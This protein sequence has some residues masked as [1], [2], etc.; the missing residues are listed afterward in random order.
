MPPDLGHDVAPI[1][2]MC[3]MGVAVV[4]AAIVAGCGTSTSA[5]PAIAPATSLAP[6]GSPSPTAPAAPVTSPSPTPDISSAALRTLSRMPVTGMEG[7]VSG[8]LTSSAGAWPVSGTISVVGASQQ[9][10]L[11]LTVGSATQA[12]HLVVADGKA[13]VEQGSGPWFAAP[14]RAGGY[15]PTSGATL[16]SLVTSITSA[17]DVGVESHA[18]QQLHHLT[19]NAST[20]V[21]PIAF[22]FADSSITGA[23]LTV[24]LYADDSGTPVLLAVSG[25]WQQR[26]GAS[27]AAVTAA[28]DVKL[29]ASPASVTAPE[30]VWSTFSSKRYLYHAAKPADWTYTAKPTVDELVSP[31]DAGMDLASTVTHESLAQ[32]TADVINANVRSFGK[33]PEHTESITI[34]GAP[35]RLLTYHVTQNNVKLY[36]LEAVVVHNGRGY[37]L[38]YA[39]LA[40]SEGPDRATFLEFLGTF[41]FGR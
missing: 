15:G 6:A 18:G 33:K 9:S 26:I 38:S 31:E 17:T 3:L 19:T 27:V 5:T 2:S 10:D 36:F 12:S 24:D 13:Y 14:A 20:N 34:A 25:G 22:G 41:G 29:R 1:R 28:F 4:V 7:D 16:D 39:D 8:T 40:G 21:A 32:V 11:E 35:A 37:A 30:E 23:A